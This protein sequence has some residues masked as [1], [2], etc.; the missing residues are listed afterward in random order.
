MDYKIIEDKKRS[1]VQGWK[2]KELKREETKAEK[3]VP[4]LLIAYFLSQHSC[5]NVK[6][7]RLHIFKTSS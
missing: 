6:V 3:P 1:K 2:L 7:L 4:N 5:R